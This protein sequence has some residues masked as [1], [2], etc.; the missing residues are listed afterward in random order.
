MPG[1]DPKRSISFLH[2]RRLAKRNFCAM[3]IYKAVVGDLNRPA[4]N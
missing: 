1:F 2:S 4:I 3:E